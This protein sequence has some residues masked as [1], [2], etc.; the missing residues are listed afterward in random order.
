MPDPCQLC[1]D[2]GM[3][4]IERPDGSRVAKECECR[5]QRRQLRQLAAARIPDRYI[6]CTLDDYEPG[7]AGANGSL[8]KAL[9]MARSFVRSY[10]LETDGNGLLLT[11]SIGVGK[12]H[13]AIGMLRALMQERG[14][15]GLFYD[16]RDL[17]KQIQNSYNKSAGPSEMEILRPVFEAEVLVLDELGAGK[18]TEW[19]W[20][21]V[22]HVL[23]TRYN[24]RRTT[25]LTT[26]Y[27]NLPPAGFDSQSTVSSIRA[28]AR[29][30]TLGDRIGERMRSRLQEMCVPVE[31]TGTDFRQRVRR[32]AY[33]SWAT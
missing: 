31:M 33:A 17:L 4:L 10:P 19:V 30:E 5:A 7:F 11:G 2:S 1:G 14:A 12:T 6:H 22:A 13:L 25:I 24:D 26:N 3:Y 16:Y 23:N 9:V 15:L 20:E 8:S 18:P 21:T 29:E 27:A 28:A 32:A